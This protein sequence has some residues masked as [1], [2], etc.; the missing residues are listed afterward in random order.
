[1]PSSHL[2]PTACLKGEGVDYFTLSFRQRN[3]SSPTR[4]ILPRNEADFDSS[5]YIHNSILQD[6]VLWETGKQPKVCPQKTNSVCMCVVYVR[7]MGV[8]SVRNCTE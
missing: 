3:N 6:F 8:E 2:P 5:D 7:E 4:H 1:M